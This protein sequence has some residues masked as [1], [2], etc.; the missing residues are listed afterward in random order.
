MVAG[1]TSCVIGFWRC[2]MSLARR[3]AGVNLFL[4]AVYGPGTRLSTLLGMR[5]DWEHAW[6]SKG[7]RDRWRLGRAGPVGHQQGMHRRQPLQVDPALRG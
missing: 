2:E 3:L 6:A 7:A 4:E 1:C 5:Q